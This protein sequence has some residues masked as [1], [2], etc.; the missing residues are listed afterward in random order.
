MYSN[1]NFTKVRA[2]YWAWTFN[3]C[4]LLPPHRTYWR[5][6]KSI[7]THRNWTYYESAVR[8]DL[9][10]EHVCGL[11]A[12]NYN[13]YVFLEHVALSRASN[14]LD[15]FVYT[16]FGLFFGDGVVGIYFKRLPLHE[17]KRTSQELS[18]SRKF[19][20]LDVNTRKLDI[21]FVCFL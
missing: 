4:Y 17:H 18:F 21:K 12:T 3:T 1:G 9:E 11:R 14:D 16:L 5:W 6:I 13:F 19:Q 10:Q 7:E 15:L 20:S 8:V 2:G